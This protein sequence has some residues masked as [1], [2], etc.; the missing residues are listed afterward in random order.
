M[1]KDAIASGREIA[2]PDVT[3]VHATERQAKLA[4]ATV[5]RVTWHRGMESR[6]ERSEEDG[7]Q[8]IVVR[9][10]PL[11]G[12]EAIIT[13]G[14]A[15]VRAGVPG[16]WTVE[17]DSPKIAGAFDSIS[18]VGS[19]VY[20]SPLIF[21]R[22]VYEREQAIEVSRALETIALDISNDPYSYRLKD[23]KVFISAGERKRA[24]RVMAS[25][26]R[27]ETFGG[28]KK[29]NYNGS[30]VIQKQK[31]FLWGPGVVE[32]TL[33]SG[34][35]TLRFGKRH[36]RVWW[37]ALGMPVIEVEGGL[38]D[39]CYKRTSAW[40]SFDHKP[41]IRHIMLPISPGLLHTKMAQWELADDIERHPESYRLLR[42]ETA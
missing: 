17:L 2:R 18:N 31:Q 41:S 19:F 30:I 20:S 38:V 1:E 28:T 29:D 26:L 34:I 10:T 27:L 11:L 13:L 36:N 21:R 32:I 5:M 33:G 3:R 14:R 42:S 4:V 16:S 40:G 6:A 8:K 35:G 24:L 22:P 39:T 7:K 15:S 9:K 12:K 37:P 23:D 25:M